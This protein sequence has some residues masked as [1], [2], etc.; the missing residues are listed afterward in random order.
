[1]ISC[2]EAICS[3]E[4]P[5]LSLI[6][7]VLEFLI[8]TLKTIRSDGF[9][10]ETSSVG[11]EIVQLI[12][13]MVNDFD[14]EKIILKLTLL[15]ELL[16]CLKPQS[17]RQC[18]LKVISPKLRHLN[19]PELYDDII[20]L[21]GCLTRNDLVQLLEGDQSEESLLSLTEDL[22]EFSSIL[23]DLL[24]KEYYNQFY[25]SIESP[26][27]CLNLFLLPELLKYDDLILCKRILN[28]GYLRNTSTVLPQRIQLENA[29]D[30]IEPEYTKLM[31]VK[32]N[33]KVIESQAE[34]TEVNSSSVYEFYTEVSTNIKIQISLIPSFP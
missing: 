30:W 23:I 11:K 20:K 3:A 17:S 32:L 19:R 24:P 16:T 2:E 26:S 10:S 14:F 9:N 12:D 15:P 6:E 7:K 33:L 5:T 29:L 4:S 22:K 8:K 18:C 21:F 28:T 31:T 13:G 25:E 34:F 27:S 1:M